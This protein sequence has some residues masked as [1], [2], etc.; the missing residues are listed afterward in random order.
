MPLPP[1]P[2]LR[3]AIGDRLA[4]WQGSRTC[5]RVALERRLEGFLE[6]SWKA[7]E[8]L[9]EDPWDALK[10]I[11]IKGRLWKA[12]VGGSLGL[13]PG[14]RVWILKICLQYV[15]FLS[16]ACRDF[17]AGAA[18]G[19]VAKNQMC[20]KMLCSRGL[21]GLLGG[22][23]AETDWVS[24]MNTA[25]TLWSSLAN[26]VW[27]GANFLPELNTALTFWSFWVRKVREGGSFLPELS[28][29][30]AFLGPYNLKGALHADDLE[31]GQ[32][33]NQGVI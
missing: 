15:S 31:V 19:A 30:L 11:L 6:G 9:L 2:H 32:L 26:K 8:R 28:T 18:V 16:E 4:A 1:T 20:F 21:S 14:K 24:E 17:R 10:N 3:S 7:L 23:V 29:A 5:A 25:L 12:P 27:E 33:L 22:I 13:L